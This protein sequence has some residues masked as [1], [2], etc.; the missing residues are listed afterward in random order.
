M[1]DRAGGSRRVW[2]IV[3]NPKEWNWGRLVKEKRVSY[4]YGR[5]RRNYPH[6]K[7]GDLVIGYQSTP[8]KRVVA[9][10]RVSP[11]RPALDAV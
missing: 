4:R 9:L 8:D 3:A 1:F 5:L 6:V 2:W 7:V 10:A 11:S